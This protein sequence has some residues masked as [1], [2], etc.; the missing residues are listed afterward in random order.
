VRDR[1]PT[2]RD[3]FPKSWKTFLE[4]REGREFSNARAFANQSLLQHSGVTR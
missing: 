1:D 2:I 4:N 3:F